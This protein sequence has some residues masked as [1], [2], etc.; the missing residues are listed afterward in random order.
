[1]VLTSEDES[2]RFDLVLF[3]EVSI[4]FLLLRS[5]GAQ[6]CCFIIII[7]VA[8][9]T[10]WKAPFL[11]VLNRLITLRVLVL[12][13][14]HDELIDAPIFVTPIRQVP[15]DDDRYFSF[16]QFLLGDPKRIRLSVQIHHDGSVHADLQRPGS[17]HACLFVF[18][19]IPRRDAFGR[20]GSCR[21]DR[22]SLA[23]PHG[24]VAFS[25]H[26]EGIIVSGADLIL[27]TFCHVGVVHL[28]I[29]ASSE[30]AAGIVK[31]LVGTD[32]VFVVAHC[33]CVLRGIALLC[34]GFGFLYHFGSLVAEQEV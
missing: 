34:F 8:A 4:H 3:G 17:Q 1:M 20:C 25:R 12:P 13:L 14:I 7:M 21:H 27:G 33:V 11:L 26:V 24:I 18:R 31:A 19:E 15:S 6:V 5:S 23:A 2:V 29:L 9:I 28:L 32:W 10:I 22:I 16:S 30:D